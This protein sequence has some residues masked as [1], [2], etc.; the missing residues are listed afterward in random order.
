MQKSLQEADTRLSRHLKIKEGIEMSRLLHME[1][2]RRLNFPWMPP[3]S[4]KVSEETIEYARERLVEVMESFEELLTHIA[5]YTSDA[6]T[7]F[8]RGR[9]DSA[10][11]I[12]Q[13]V[14]TILK[15]AN[16]ENP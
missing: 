15:N 10:L 9:N 12:R 5:E 13:H 4:Y 14:K 6:K 2:H 7:E 11:D 1:L 16:Q 3:A 8:D